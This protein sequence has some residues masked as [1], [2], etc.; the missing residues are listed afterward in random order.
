MLLILLFL[1][2]ATEFHLLNHL[3][4]KGLKVT[5]Y[6]ILPFCDLNFTSIK[7]DFPDTVV[8][9]LI[10]VLLRFQETTKKEILMY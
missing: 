8:R 3:I 9:M 1:L 2:L 10:G 5:I 6:S 4:E 7:F